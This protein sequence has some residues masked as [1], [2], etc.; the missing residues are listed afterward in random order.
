MPAHPGRVVQ[1][2]LHQAVAHY[3]AASQVAL[4]SGGLQALV[5]SP[6]YSFGMA[7]LL[8]E[9]NDLAGAEQHI[10][11]GME[12]MQ[13]ALTLHAD[14]AAL[15][16]LTRARLQFACGNTLGARATLATFVDFARQRQFDN[17]MLARELAV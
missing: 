5:G 2:R 6:A 9:W 17:L 4:G 1:G 12:L 14:V 7:D 10:V 11:Q 13:G 3:H 16:Y 15:G 8:R